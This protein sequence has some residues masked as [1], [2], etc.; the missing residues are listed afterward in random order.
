MVS[1]SKSSTSFEMFEQT[2]TFNGVDT[3]SVTNYG[4]FDFNSKLTNEYEARLLINRP[5]IN[6]H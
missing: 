6:A 1:A 3:C 2:G 4:N 5:D